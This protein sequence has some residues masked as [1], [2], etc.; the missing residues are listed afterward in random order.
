[1]HNMER[2]CRFL[3]YVQIKGYSLVQSALQKYKEKKNAVGNALL[4]CINTLP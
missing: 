1:M 2:L 4:I 3:F